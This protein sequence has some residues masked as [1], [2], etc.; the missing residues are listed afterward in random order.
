MLDRRT[1]YK[2]RHIGA[3]TV[4]LVCL[5]IWGM[6][7]RTRS[8]HVDNLRGSRGDNSYRL[9]YEIVNPTSERRAITVLP[10]V[11]LRLYSGRES[12]DTLAAEEHSLIMEPNE[13]RAFTS[14]IEYSRVHLGWSPFR[15]QVLIRPNRFP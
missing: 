10:S 9:Q 7:S 1:L 2:N 14:H 15:P 11:T 13:T 3:L 5:A 12:L 6:L 8:V 4:V